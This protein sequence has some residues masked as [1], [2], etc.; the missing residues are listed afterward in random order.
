MEIKSEY[1]IHVSDYQPELLSRPV[2]KMGK[3]ETLE[4]LGIIIVECGVWNT[5]E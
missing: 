1:L 3:S 2:P 5:V 4:E